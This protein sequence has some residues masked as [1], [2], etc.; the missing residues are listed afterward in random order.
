MNLQA[1]FLL[2]AMGLN[3]WP[4]AHQGPCPPGNTMVPA[5][6]GHHTHTEGYGLLKR[7]EYE[8]PHPSTACTITIMM[9]MMNLTLGHVDN[10]CRL[11]HI[12]DQ[13]NKLSRHPQSTYESRYETMVSAYMVQWADTMAYTKCT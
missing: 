12:L 6:T 2:A 9:M 7:L 1:P 8:Q 3:Q 10:T 11:Q 5:F 13:T 4:E